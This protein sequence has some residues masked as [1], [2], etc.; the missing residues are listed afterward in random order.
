[1][2]T[3]LSPV[4]TAIVRALDRLAQIGGVLTT[5]MIWLL[6]ITVTYDVVLR[7]LGVP[8]LWAAEVSIYLMIAMAFLGAGATQKVDGHFR[9]TFVRDLCPPRLRTCLDIFAS[10]TTTLFAVLFTIGA[11]K[12]TSFSWMLDF[13]TSTLLEIP[14]WILQGLM[15]VGGILLTLATLRDL[16]LTSMHGSAARDSKAG[17]GEVI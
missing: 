3:S 14:L 4:P 6:A 5:L 12:V 11:W 13:K 15:L 2:T 7:S 9:V 8:T 10:L 1:M 17:A 16:L